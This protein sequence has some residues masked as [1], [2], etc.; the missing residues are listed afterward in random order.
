MPEGELAGRVR[1]G[2]GREAEVFA[3][4]G[5]TVLR[6]LRPS[7]DPTRIEREAVALRAAADGGVDVPKVHGT[8]T[9]DGR[10]AVIMERVDGPDLI[11]LMGKR[12]WTVPRAARIVGRAQ[13]RMHDLI[14]PDDLPGLREVVRRK[15]AA[16]AD[17]PAELADFALKK[18]DALPDS[19]R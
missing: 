9:V 16:A 4:D 3:W 18:L 7:N 11:A 17:L 8:T 12:P 2:E 10:A 5:G 15:I 1:V 19:G 13:A 14:A 6:V